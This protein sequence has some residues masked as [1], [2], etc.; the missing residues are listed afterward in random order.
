MQG[1][2]AKVTKKELV[3]ESPQQYRSLSETE[4]DTVPQVA[5]SQSS[6]ADGSSCFFKKLFFPSYSANRGKSL[7]KLTDPGA[8]VT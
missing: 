6:G 3:I 1:K 4:V 7:R 5:V 8:G 2:T